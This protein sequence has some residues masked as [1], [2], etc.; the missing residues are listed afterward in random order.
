M[1][2]KQEWDSLA[3]VSKWLIATGCAVTFFYG[4]QFGGWL[5]LGLIVDTLLPVIPFTANLAPI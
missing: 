2:N 1:A 3:G 4:P 5:I